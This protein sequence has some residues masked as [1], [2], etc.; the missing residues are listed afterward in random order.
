MG[1]F[2]IYKD[3]RRE[4]RFRLKAKNGQTILTGEVYASK[5]GCENGIDSIRKNSIDDSRYDCLTSKSGKPY[6]NLKAGNNQLIGNSQMYSSQKA[7]KNG[8]E[9]V[10]KNASGAAVIEL[11]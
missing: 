3:K 11:S 6:F 2:E 4:F 10:K 5:S 7:M 1:K 8:I 9:S